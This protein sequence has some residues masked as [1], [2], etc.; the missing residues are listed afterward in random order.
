MITYL[1]FSFHN[2]WWGSMS[3]FPAKQYI[4]RGQYTRNR[5]LKCW[6][7]CAV[8]TINFEILWKIRGTKTPKVYIKLV[9]LG[10]IIRKAYFFQFAGEHHKIL[11]KVS[12]SLRGCPNAWLQHL[13]TPSRN[14]HLY[15]R[16]W[17]PKLEL[18]RSLF[19]DLATWSKSEHHQRAISFVQQ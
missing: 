18:Q 12:K 16:S 9:K 6:L 14:W 15:W 2:L 11:G 3:G 5:H 19:T 13:E 7:Y 1:V 10:N 4:G 8:K 17:P